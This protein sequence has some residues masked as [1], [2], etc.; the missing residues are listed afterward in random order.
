[1]LIYKPSKYFLR[2]FAMIPGLKNL[3]FQMMYS[4]LTFAVQ[5][6][7]IEKTPKM[8]FLTHSIYKS[9]SHAYY[10]LAAAE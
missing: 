2:C 10:T 3:Y 8:T 6:I 4:L 9:A 7:Q 1:M 5:L